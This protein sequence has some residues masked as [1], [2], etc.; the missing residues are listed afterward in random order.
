MTNCPVC[1]KAVDPLRAPAVGVLDGK[2][3]SFCSREHAAELQS[4]PTARP[5]P[6]T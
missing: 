3:V 2:V 1:G 5:A 4:K 6:R